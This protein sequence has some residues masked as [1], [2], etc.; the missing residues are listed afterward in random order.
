MKNILLASALLVVS[1]SAAL[2]QFPVS[3]GD[4][5]GGLAEGQKSIVDLVSEGY[6]IKATV[7]PLIILQDDKVLYG[8]SAGRTGPADLKAG[9]IPASKIPCVPIK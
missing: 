2:A 4:P 6:E 9:V 8:C 5:A 3:E 7:G 1:S